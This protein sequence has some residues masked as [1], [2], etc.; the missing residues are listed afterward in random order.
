MEALYFGAAAAALFVIGALSVRLLRTTGLEGIDLPETVR[1][2]EGGKDLGERLEALGAR[3][4]GLTLRWYGPE[5]IKKLDVRLRAAGRPGGLTVLTYL[6]RQSGFVVVGLALL[7]AM[8]LLDEPFVGVL[9]FVALVAWMPWWLSR[10]AS[11]RRVRLNREL[12][13]FLDVLAVTIAAGLGFRQA[14]ERVASFHDGPIA[15]EVRTALQEMGMG[16]S[17]R[18][19]LVAM[20][21]RVES[22]GMSAFVTALLQAEEL[23]VPLG[24]AVTSIAE[25]V[26]Q[27]RAQEVRQAAAK[28]GTK[29]SLVVTMLI[30]PGAMVLILAGLFLGNG[31][32]GAM[33]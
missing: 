4:L 23:G 28:A 17:R 13:D 21:E 20:R 22:P 29:V 19:S 6:R 14:M 3:F 12:P 30:V 1:S 10:M 25:D 8:V 7:L 18:R 5:R 31:G 11:S 33:F 16:V 24:T 26:R 27:E 2:E 32:L 9:L 15:D